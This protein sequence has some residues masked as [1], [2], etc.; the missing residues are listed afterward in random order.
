MAAAPAP[1]SSADHGKVFRDQFSVEQFLKITAVMV[2]M[3]NT[4]LVAG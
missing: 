3:V 1:T 4:T 2:E